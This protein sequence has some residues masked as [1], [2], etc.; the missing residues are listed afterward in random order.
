MRRVKVAYFGIFVLSE[1]SRA[2]GLCDRFVPNAQRDAF[3]GFAAVSRHRLFRDQ[4]RHIGA[5]AETGLAPA[6]QGSF[7]Q[8]VRDCPVV[9]DV[10]MAL[11]AFPGS[12]TNPGDLFDYC[13]HFV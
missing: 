6:V 12:L 2:S 10:L 5:L 3:I 9:G 1:M 7:D 13:G 11:F 8:V 4:A